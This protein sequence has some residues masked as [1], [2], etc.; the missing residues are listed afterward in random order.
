MDVRWRPGVVLKHIGIIGINMHGY[1]L[2]L[3]DIHGYPGIPVDL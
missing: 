1:P 3:T 2:T